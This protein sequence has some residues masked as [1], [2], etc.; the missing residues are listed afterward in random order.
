M[1]ISVTKPSVDYRGS[2]DMG[3]G[4]LHEL[5]IEVVGGVLK[6][7]QI[8]EH[9]AFAIFTLSRDGGKYYFLSSGDK[10][11]KAEEIARQVKD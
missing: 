3:D 2:L 1:K 9:N 6:A 5:K 8:V 10:A 7:S 4:K 11:D